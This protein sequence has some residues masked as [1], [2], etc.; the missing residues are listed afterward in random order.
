MKDENIPH[1]VLSGEGKMI[2]GDWEPLQPQPWIQTVEK[3]NKGG[4][5]QSVAFGDL[6]A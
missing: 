3:A 1:W 6:A 2:S 5:S 4:T